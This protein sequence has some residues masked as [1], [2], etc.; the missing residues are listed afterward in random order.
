MD[1]NLKGK[2]FKGNDALDF[3]FFKMQIY[4]FLAFMSL[5]GPLHINAAFFSET[6]TK[7]NYT[8]G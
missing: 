1:I 7:H 4:L 5:N 6:S 3:F 2:T 8:G